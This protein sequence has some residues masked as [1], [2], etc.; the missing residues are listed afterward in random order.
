MKH[1]EEKESLF[2]KMHN[3]GLN[4]YFMH[5]TSKA[6]GWATGQ[7][8]QAVMPLGSEARHSFS[9]LQIVCCQM[10]RLELTDSSIH[11][12]LVVPFFTQDMPGLDV[13]H[14]LQS[15]CSLFCFYTMDLVSYL[16]EL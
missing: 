16:A 14:S 3:T 1:D 7:L 5:T 8:L 15:T 11:F 12:F 6:V 2:K 9:L 10:Q 13:S 4:N